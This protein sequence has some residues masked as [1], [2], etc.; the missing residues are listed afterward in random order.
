MA[1]LTLL[2]HFVIVILLPAATSMAA[3]LPQASPQ[4]PPQALSQEAQQAFFQEPPQ[5]LQQGAQVEPQQE[6]PQTASATAVRAGPD[7]P[8]AVDTVAFI[9]R[10]LLAQGT[11]RTIAG[12]PVIY[13]A[14]TTPVLAERPM[15]CRVQLKRSLAGQRGSYEAEVSTFGL[16]RHHRLHYTLD[17]GV[18]VK[19]SWR[20]DA[21]A[22]G[23]AAAQPEGGVLF[24]ADSAA[25]AERLRRAFEHLKAAC[26]E[27]LPKAHAFDRSVADLEKPL[28]VQPAPP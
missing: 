8:S 27:R 28:A 6:V 21:D 5:A 23:P 25:G 12:D 1:K 2:P 19:G 7:E 16:V 22:T 15:G 26:A 3:S 20:Y 17:H 4:E 9:E 14:L 10:E 18:Q 11:Q 13:H 24:R